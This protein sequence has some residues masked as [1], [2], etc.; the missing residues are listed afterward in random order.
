MCCLTVH[1]FCDGACPGEQI[2][3]HWIFV[4]LLECE[5]AGSFPT[6]SELTSLCSPTY[7]TYCRRFLFKHSI[8]SGRKEEIWS[9]KAR[10]HPLS[11]MLPLL[12][13]RFPVSMTSWCWSLL[14]EDRSGE[15]TRFFVWRFL[16]T[17]KETICCFHDRSSKV[18]LA[19]KKNGKDQLY[20]IKVVK[21]TE[22]INKNM[23]DQGKCLISRAAEWEWCCRHTLPRFSLCRKERTGCQP[24]PLHC[25]SVLL[26]ADKCQC[27]S[28]K[29]HELAFCSQ[30]F[31]L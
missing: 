15:L 10:M 8:R 2:T 22:M 18:Y 12:L 11:H 23:V 4:T 6:L 3:C 7:G 21:K 13:H 27:L 31:C 20:A 14:A 5:H 30:I 26:I 28:G 16:D 9:R 1:I 25:P 17:T 29:L 19:Q 24:K